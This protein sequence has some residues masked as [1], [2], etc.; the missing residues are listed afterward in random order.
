MACWA[1]DA[2]D[3]DVRTRLL[4]E[5]VLFLPPDAPGALRARLGRLR[6]GDLVVAKTHDADAGLTLHAVG[7]VVAES[8]DEVAGGGLGLAVK[9]QWTGQKKNAPVTL[10]PLGDGDDALRGRLLYEEV[11]P[12]VRLKALELL[13][14][15]TEA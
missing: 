10:P 1:L 15:G 11:S 12:T 3:P 6:I 14:V 7:A 8:V 4:A 9:W 5:G 13:F 2:P